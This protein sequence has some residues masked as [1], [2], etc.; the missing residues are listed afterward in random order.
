MIFSTISVFPHLVPTF[1]WINGKINSMKFTSLPPRRNII[2]SSD[3]TLK[4]ITLK[5]IH[6]RLNFDQRNMKKNLQV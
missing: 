5:D 4:D 3:I 1:G 6:M 2:F